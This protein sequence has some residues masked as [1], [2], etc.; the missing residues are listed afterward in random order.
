MSSSLSSSAGAPMTDSG[1]GEIA[2]APESAVDG[3]AVSDAADE[4][5]SAATAGREVISTASARVVV[6]DVADAV[7]SI[8]NDAEE[9]GGH[10]SEE[11]RGGK[12]CVSTCGSRGVPVP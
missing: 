9:R 8:A 6:A 1:G 5:G 2:V 7:G 4:A 3:R 10:R 11:R 12:G